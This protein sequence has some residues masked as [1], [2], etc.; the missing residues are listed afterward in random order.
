MAGARRMNGL[1]AAALLST[2]GLSGCATVSSLLTPPTT[3]TPSTLA[4]APPSTETPRPIQSQSPDTS[5]STSKPAT[6]PAA[7]KPKTQAGAA[8]FVAFFWQQFNRSQM[9][10][11]PALLP[12]LF[13]DSCAPCAAYVD[14]A[15]ALQKGRQH[16]ASPPFVVKSVKT[17]TLKGSTA[18]VLSPV[19]QQA[20][21]VADSSNKTL[22][23]ATEQDQE[24]LVT[25]MWNNNGWKVSDIQVVT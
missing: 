3:V 5:Q 2:L 11:N 9:E 10:A 19:T 23:V 24:F 18:T 16:Y 8:A 22:A 6:V 1:L 17:D 7:A 20:A 14:G 12:G 15:T 25:L 13:Q 4:M 21:A